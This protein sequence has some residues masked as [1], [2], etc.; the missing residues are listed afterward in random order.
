MDK[1]FRGS[2]EFLRARVRG[3]RAAWACGRLAEVADRIYVDLDLDVL[4]RSFAPATPGSRP[5]GMQPSDL[6]EAA[7]CCGKHPK[8]R[9]I[10]LVEIDPEKDVA[11]VTV[12]MAASCF[13][14]FAA[15]YI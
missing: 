6:L 8:V 7:R 10:D 9:A 15:G 11:N 14:A 3:K 4:D 1:A 13:L 12:L 2:R 5:G